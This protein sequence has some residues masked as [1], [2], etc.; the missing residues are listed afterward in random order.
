MLATKIHWKENL[1]IERVIPYTQ[2][3]A[4][5]GLDRLPARTSCRQPLS[6]GGRALPR[7]CPYL[8]RGAT[9]RAH[10]GDGIWALRAQPRRNGGARRPG[11]GRPEAAAVADPAVQGL[12]A[13]L[14]RHHEPARPSGARR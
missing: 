4:Q 14:G 11:S 5:E 7:D 8:A 9:H 6:E 10:A 3:H 1:A 12:D 2:A 13:L